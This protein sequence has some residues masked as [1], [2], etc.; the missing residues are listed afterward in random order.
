M[1][2][3]E[4][5]HAI[6]RTIETYGFEIGFAKVINID[7]LIAELSDPRGNITVAIDLTEKGGG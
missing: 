7:K 2:L 3:A 4:L 1:T 6:K 5:E